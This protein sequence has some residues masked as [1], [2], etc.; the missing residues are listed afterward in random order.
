M[1]DT[2]MKILWSFN[3]EAQI[4]RA[5]NSM[6]STGQCT[7]IVKNNYYGNEYQK[8]LRVKYGSLYKFDALAELS[9]NYL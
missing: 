6:L 2:V 7:D 8:F 5:S 4:F 3:K 9:V 1:I